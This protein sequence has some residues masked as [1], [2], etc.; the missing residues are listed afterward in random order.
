MIQ[1]R[2]NPYFTDSERS[3]GCEERE[4]WYGEESEGD[5]EWYVIKSLF[6]ETVQLRLNCIFLY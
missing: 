5:E 4:D 2:K 6:G 3:R 1:T